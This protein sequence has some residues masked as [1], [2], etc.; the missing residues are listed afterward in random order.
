MT[1]EFMLFILLHQ[2]VVKHLRR[3]DKFPL[4]GMKKEVSTHL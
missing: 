4:S 2:S 3:Q 1:T